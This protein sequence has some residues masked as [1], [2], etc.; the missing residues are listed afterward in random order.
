MRLYLLTVVVFSALMC[1]GQVGI[2]ANYGMSNFEQFK[3]QAY[4]F[5][6]NKNASFLGSAIGFGIDY[7]FRLKKRRIEFLPELA[8]A[9]FSKTSI[10]N[11]SYNAKSISFYFNTQIY[12]LDLAEDCDC[13]T[14]SKQGNTVKKGFFFHVSPAVKSFNLE[15]INGS[16]T[17]SSNA[18]TFGIRAGFG[19][20]LGINDFA[21]I[22]PMFSYERTSMAK[23]ENMTSINEDNVSEDISSN[24]SNLNFGLRFGMRFN[25]NTKKFRR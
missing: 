2:R 4:L 13:P 19:L 9:S 20:D 24:Y 12:L 5:E 16:L 7:W 10:S 3:D 8:Y 15:G 17:N 11:I 23:W 14:F 1:Y 22:T 21:T 18:L 25:Q 6:S